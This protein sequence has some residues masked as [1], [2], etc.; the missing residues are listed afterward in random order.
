MRYL[1][2]D[3]GRRR[4]GLALSDALGVTCSPHVIVE[5][6]NPGQ[7]LLRIVEIARNEGVGEI[8]VGIPRPLSGGTNAQMEEVLGLVRR[9]RDSSEIAVTTWDERFTSKMAEAGR[10]RRGRSDDVAA[11]YMLQGYLDSR[12]KDRG[13][14]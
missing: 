1:G 12:A 8:V 9:L 13:S 4:T 5:E 11:C 2:V 3:V 7:L 14:T 10:V 6:P